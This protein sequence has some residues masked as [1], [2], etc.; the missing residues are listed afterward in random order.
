MSRANDIRS[1]TCLVTLARPGTA[2]Q[3]VLLEWIMRPAM[4]RRWKQDKTFEKK[5]KAAS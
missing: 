4:M 5:L 2:A 3:R 1:L